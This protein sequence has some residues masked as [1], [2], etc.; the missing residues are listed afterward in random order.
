MEK[1]E[2]KEL[3]VATVHETLV[4]LGAD[5]K[6]PIEMQKDFQAMRQFRQTSEAIK[7]KG[8]VTLIGTL[9]VSIL[10]LIGFG[11]K[12]YFGR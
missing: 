11:L 3:V 4:G 10:A 5:P 8:I 9:V 2:V 1:D 7:R 6:H 12:D